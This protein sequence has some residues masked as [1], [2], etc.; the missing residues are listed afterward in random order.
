VAGPLT[1]PSVARPAP[2]AA[3]L[4]LRALARAAYT[5]AVDFRR[6]SAAWARL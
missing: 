5:S 4:A 2:A 6:M 1:G 3:Y